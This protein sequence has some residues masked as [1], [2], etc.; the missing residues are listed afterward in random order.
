[1]S[2]TPNSVKLAVSNPNFYKNQNEFWQMLCY[3]F[4]D[5]QSIPVWR[6]ID[7]DTF[8]LIIEQ[9]HV[10]IENVYEYSVLTSN[11]NLL[12]Q[13][14]FS[15]LTRIKGQRPLTLFMAKEKTSV[16]QAFH[17]LYKQLFRMIVESKGPYMPIFGSVKNK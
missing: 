2:L 15:A 14:Y 6:Q 10:V 11:Q 7:E 5:Y 4:T 13:V 3:L 8:R 9:L 17:H 1:M 16:L 12:E